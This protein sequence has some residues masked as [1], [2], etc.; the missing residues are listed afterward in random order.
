MR[1]GFSIIALAALLFPFQ[2]LAQDCTNPDG[3]IGQVMYLEGEDVFAGCSINAGWVAFHNPTGFT[4]DPCAA[5]ATPGTTCADG[6]IYA[7]LSP[8]GNVPMYTTPADAP[9]TYSWNDG[10]TNWVDTAMVNCTGT[11]SSCR[12]GEA[13]TN[14]LVSLN[15]SG[16]PAPYE[17]AQYCADLAPPDP[18]AL[19]HSDWYLPARDELT[20]LYDNRTS[21]GG[22]TTSSTW[23]WSSSESSSSHAHGRD[24]TGGPGSDP[25]RVNSLVRC[26]RK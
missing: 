2:A 9:G 21:I 13:N 10:S 3:V 23:N 7:G 17:A 24:F 18:A 19:G 4:P 16:S 8:D 12:T 5:S 14:L 1:R 15:G 26:V 22:F 20:V 25:K 6:S 11:A